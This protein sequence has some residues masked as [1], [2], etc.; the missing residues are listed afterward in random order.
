[1]HSWFQTAILTAVNRHLD[2]LLSG[3]LL[4]SSAAV[5]S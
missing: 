4:L 1:L 3:A 2:L 5:G